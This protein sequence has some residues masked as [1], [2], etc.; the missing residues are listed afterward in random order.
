[1]ARGN[2]P[3]FVLVVSALGVNGVFGTR[4]KLAAPTKGWLR[5]IGGPKLAK[6]LFHD[7][8][9]YIILCKQVLALGTDKTELLKGAKQ[10]WS[11]E[12]ALLPL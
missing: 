6:W 3:S 4:G 9:T 8:H 12:S 10:A 1:V 5:G 11:L 2:I 7:S